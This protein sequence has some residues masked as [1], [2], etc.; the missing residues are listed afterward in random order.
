MRHIHQRSVP[1]RRA[2]FRRP[3]RPRRDGLVHQLLR[4][5]RDQH[6]VALDAI[7]R[8]STSGKDYLNQGFVAG[9]RADE[10]PT[11]TTG[12]DHGSCR[13]VSEQ[14]VECRA[15]RTRSPAQIWCAIGAVRARRRRPPSAGG[16][17]PRDVQEMWPDKTYVLFTY[18]RLRDAVVAPPMALGCFGGDTDNFEWPRHTADFTLLRGVAP[19]A[20]GQYCPTMC[21][22]RRVSARRARRC[23]AGR[24]RSSSAFRAPPCG[25]RRRAA[26]VQRRGGGAAA[27]PTLARSSS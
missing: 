5:H 6:H 22:T 23:G 7:R 12:V 13:R 25:T 24:F 9:S 10:L 16:L 14:L 1:L 4:S 3:G 17:G 18:E 11:R 27:V 2:G 20:G 19:T 8:A 21:R 26:V 15:E